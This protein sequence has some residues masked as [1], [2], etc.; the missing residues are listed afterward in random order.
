MPPL[1]Y[2]MGSAHVYS[3]DSFGRLL[4]FEFDFFSLTKFFVG[5]FAVVD[6]HVFAP[7]KRLDESVSLLGTKPFYLSATHGKNVFY[8]TES[9]CPSIRVA[10]GCVP[11]RLPWLLTRLAR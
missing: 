8:S 7:F 6:E 10:P 9:S 5:H 4:R 1:K 11:S 2:F 3:A